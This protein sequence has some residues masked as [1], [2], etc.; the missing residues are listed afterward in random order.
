MRMTLTRK[1]V[2]FHIRR[3]LLVRTL[4]Q[5]AHNRSSPTVRRW[6]TVVVSASNRRV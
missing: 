5:C 6:E 4:A 2:R 3:C 1:Q